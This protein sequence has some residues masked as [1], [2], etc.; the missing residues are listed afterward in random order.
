MIRRVALATLTVAMALSTTQTADAQRLR[1][2]IAARMAQRAEARAASAPAPAGVEIDRNVAYGGDKAQTFDVYRPSGAKGA[3]IVVMVHGGGWR[4]GDKAMDRVVE[5]KVKWLTARGLIF[6]SINY[7]M[8]PQTGV[9]EQAAD[10]ARAVASVQAKADSWGGD[11]TKLVL[12]GH[13]A[14]AHLVTLLTAEPALAAQQGVKPWRGT[15]SLDSA[16]MDVSTIMG[17]RHLKLYDE[18]FGQDPIVWRA[19]S[20]L[21]QMKAATAPL[22]LVCSSRRTD[23]CPQAKALADKAVGFGGKATVLPQDLSHGEI[24]A[25]LGEPGAYTDAV[26]HFIE[27]LTR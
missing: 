12:M 25:K 14:G 10:V 9:A 7:R 26:Q 11:P 6:V 5:N 8:L 22:L 1:D 13:S 24:N 2:R 4:I 15:V 23:S 21:H 17:G 20:P 18:A 19:L 16:A 27:T 3:A